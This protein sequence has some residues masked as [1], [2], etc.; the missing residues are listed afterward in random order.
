MLVAMMLNAKEKATAKYSCT[1]GNDV[2]PNAY[3]WKVAQVDSVGLAR[4]TSLLNIAEDTLRSHFQKLM[5]PRNMFAI[6]LQ[7][8]GLGELP[9]F[10]DAIRAQYHS[11]LIC[12]NCK[13]IGVIPIV[14]GL[15][16]LELAKDEAR[17]SGPGR[18]WW[19]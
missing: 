16:D 3:G 12:P 10:C 1:L 19:K 8:A 6:P 7:Y 17:Q 11:A 9:E 13:S 4:R 18:L 5:A 14:Y 2:S 15:P